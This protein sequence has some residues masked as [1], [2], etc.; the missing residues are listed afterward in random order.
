MERHSSVQ[1]SRPNK[2]GH[3]GDLQVNEG[4][5]YKK[6][7]KEAEIIREL[8]HPNIVRIFNSYEDANNFFFILEYID[9]ETLKQLLGN[10]RL[11]EPTIVGRLSRCW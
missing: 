3:E 6:T 11:D 2:I 4:F 7:K 9:R 8:M 1:I 5:D 10:G